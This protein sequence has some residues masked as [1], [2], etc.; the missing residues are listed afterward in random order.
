MDDKRPPGHRG[1]YGLLMLLMLLILVAALIGWAFLRNPPQT[2][3]GVAAPSPP[4]GALP[5]PTG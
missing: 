1:G 5:G 3:S 2:A 4:A